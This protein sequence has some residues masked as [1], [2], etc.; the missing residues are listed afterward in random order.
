MRYLSHRKVRK[1]GRKKELLKGLV[2]IFEL[3]VRN[4]ADIKV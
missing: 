1:E 4:I 2:V 3:P